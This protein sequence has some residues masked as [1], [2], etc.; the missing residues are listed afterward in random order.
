MKHILGHI[1]CS[2]TYINNSTQSPNARAFSTGFYDNDTGST[3]TFN[4]YYARS[5]RKRQPSQMTALNLQSYLCASQSQLETLLSFAA[6]SC[7]GSV[8]RRATSL[9][10]SRRT[11]RSTEI[12]MASSS[13]TSVVSKSACTVLMA[14]RTLADPFGASI[15]PVLSRPGGYKHPNSQASV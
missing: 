9:T 3:I 12:V 1:L 4:N 2:L 15:R 13:E 5:C 8:A 6:Y 10:F 7:A 11:I 14:T